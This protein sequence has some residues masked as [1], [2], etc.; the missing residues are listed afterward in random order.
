MRED[1]LFWDYKGLKIEYAR[2]LDGD[3]RS[4]ASLFVDFIREQYADKIPFECCYEWCSGPGFIGFALLAENICKTLVLADINPQAVEVVKKTV[5]SNELSDRVSVYLSD[6]LESI[7]REH[8]FD[9]VVSNPP[10]YFCLNPLYPSYNALSD[11]LRPND[12]G[13]KIHKA[14]YRQIPAYLTKNAVLCI[15]E[16]DPF[17]TKCFMPNLQSDKPLWG[18]EPFDI[19]PRPPILDFRE[20][21][22]AAG[23]S[24]ERVVQ[25]PEPS[26]PVHI[27]V[28]HNS[29][30]QDLAN[31]ITL[32]PGHVFLEQVGEISSNVYRVFGMENGQ[33]RGYVDLPDEQLWLI[34]LLELLV[35]A[36]DEGINKS[37]VCEKLGQGSE[38]N[39]SAS[40]ML[41]NMGWI[42]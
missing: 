38:L 17:A 29:S 23:L 13:W 34:D 22:S 25:L 36:A 3:G 28:S 6:N 15:E 42:V 27:V 41:K 30:R 32:R 37:K 20:M 26:V 10:N 9:L 5:A 33:L 12:P 31:R 35:H 39:D 16:V 8:Q 40:D 14:F 2:N 18:P 24:Y 19:R 4:M 21:I 7:P 1:P 11:D